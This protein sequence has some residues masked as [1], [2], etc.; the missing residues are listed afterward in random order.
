LEEPVLQFLPK[1]FAKSDFAKK[2]T[3]TNNTMARI[4]TDV[5]PTMMLCP[6]ARMYETQQQLAQTAD[7]HGT[8][9][10]NCIQE[11]V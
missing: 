4:P 1:N 6:K 11:Q 8:S 7:M 3:D 10:N 5:Q 2:R 9:H